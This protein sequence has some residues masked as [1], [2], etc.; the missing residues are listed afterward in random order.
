MR[1]ACVIGLTAVV[2]VAGHVTTFAQ[3]GIDSSKP[4]LITQ[5]RDSDNE[6][7]KLTLERLTMEMLANPES[8]ALIR[9]RNDK[10]LLQR[11]QLLRKGSR[12]IKLDEQRLTYLIVNSQDY[13]TE[14]YIID[15]CTDV[16]T[17]DGCT[18]IRALDFEVLDKLFRVRRIARRT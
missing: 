1:I 16:P 11:L 5:F 13:D 4:R 12:F 15:A 2:F 18:M 17:C 3:A 10:R 7:M 14:S 8:K 9:V 6:W